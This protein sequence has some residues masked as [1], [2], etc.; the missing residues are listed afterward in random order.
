MR[1]VLLATCP[2]LLLR[3]ACPRVLVL[4]ACSTL[5]VIAAACG[6]GSSPPPAAPV[7][8]SA[9]EAPTE[10]AR[11]LK[12][13]QTPRDPNPDAPSKIGVSHILVR[14]AELD[15]PRGATRTPEQA[16]LR[17]LEALDAL[18]SGK[19]DWDE[20]VSEYNDAS[21]D[22]LGRVAAEELTPAFADTAFSLSVNELSYVVETDRGFHIILRTE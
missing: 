4:T 13:A 6:S 14:H 15:D 9:T 11:C 5:F 20:A 22:S 16:C 3:A 17:A 21:D 12:E 8:T 19:L 1:S 18:K 2:R 10:G 7:E